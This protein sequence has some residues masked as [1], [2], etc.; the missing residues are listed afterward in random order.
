MLETQILELC[1]CRTQ[2]ASFLKEN[3]E[4]KRQLQ[5]IIDC[6]QESKRK[7]DQLTE[8]VIGMNSQLKNFLSAFLKKNNKR[9]KGIINVFYVILTWLDFIS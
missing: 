8:D 7:I 1:Q 6:E 9:K 2:V 5:G 3:E 4:L